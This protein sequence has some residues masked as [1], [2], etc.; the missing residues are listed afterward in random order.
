MKIKLKK[1]FTLYLQ[2]LSCAAS[3][4]HIESKRF[5]N[6]IIS[7][8]ITVWDFVKLYSPSN[9]RHEKRNL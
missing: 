5:S 7:Q 1:T 2:C 8:T 4:S 3:Y 9:G 6:R